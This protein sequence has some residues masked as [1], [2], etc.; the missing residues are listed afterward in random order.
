MP[1]KI[2]FT[3]LTKLTQKDVKRLIIHA[4]RSSIRR[5]AAVKPFITVPETENC[6]TLTYIHEVNP[7]TGEEDWSLHALATELTR[8]ILLQLVGTGSSEDSENSSDSEDSTD[9]SDDS[10]D[11][12]TD[13]PSEPSDEPTPE[14]P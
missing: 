2:E 5:A 14:E 4:T 6:P 1:E 10:N 9:S 12:V 13:G 7:I 3:P 11:E 8:F